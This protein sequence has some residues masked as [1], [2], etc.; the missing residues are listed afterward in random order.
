MRST[1]TQLAA[2]DALAGGR[3]QTARAKILA[4]F[5]S[6]DVKLTRAEIAARAKLPL[7]SV[8][9]RVRE[10]LDDLELAVRGT[11]KRRGHRT[12]EELIG[13]RVEAA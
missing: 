7:Q 2:F 10:L 11:T 4:L 6:T 12:E 3:R 9:G 1:A 8:C 5:T 13:L